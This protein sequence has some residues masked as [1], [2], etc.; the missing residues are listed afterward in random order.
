M[1]PNHLAFSFLFCVTLQLIQANDILTSPL[2]SNWG[3]WGEFQHCPSGTKVIGFQLKTEPW[4]SWDIVI[5]DTCQNGIRF[6]CGNPSSTGPGEPV[7]IISSSE[8]NWGK[9]GQIFW[10]DG[11][12]FARG[13]MLRSEEG[14]TAMVD[15]SATNNMRILCTEGTQWIEGDGEGWGEWTTPRICKGHQYICGLQTQ[16]E[17]PQGFFTDDTALNNIRVECCD[18]TQED[19]LSYGLINSTLQTD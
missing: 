8:G 12:G 15:E 3:I 16:V 9:W 10:C 5:D 6:Y 17:P 2:V 19:L 1:A 7:D 14:N 18:M 11:L 4:A 13:F